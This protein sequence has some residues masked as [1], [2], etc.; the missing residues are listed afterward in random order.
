LFYLSFYSGG[1]V[2]DKKTSLAVLAWV[3]R[4]I[5]FLTV[6]TLILF[7]IAGD[8]HWSGGWWY[9]GLQIV[10]ATLKGFLL[11]AVRPELQERR[12]KPGEGTKDW[13]KV[14]SP[15]MALSTLVISLVSALGYR[16]AGQ[17]DVDLWLRIL[18]VII[19]TGGY[20]LTLWSMRQNAF[21]E[22][23]V[24]IQ[25]DY[26]HQVISEGPYRLVRHPGYLGLT[27]YNIVLPVVM[28]SVWGFLGVGYYFVL[29]IWRTSLEDRFLRENLPGYADY[30]QRTRWR[31]FPGIW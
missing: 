27:L 9:L 23:S 11:I 19:G 10:N 12:K 18:A 6:S 4:M 28:E 15:L 21:F 5:I 31:L 1:I 22:G 3:I 8:W 14:L 7:L 13:D 26:N 2:M 17:W 29:L 25:S 20:L 24:R 16:L 30:A